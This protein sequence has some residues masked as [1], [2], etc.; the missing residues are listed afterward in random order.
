MAGERIA[1][2]GRVS[3]GE[4][5]V[6]VALPSYQGA[7]PAV[8][9][10]WVKAGDHVAK[11]QKL[12]VTQS[13]ALAA[14]D[15]GVAKA[16]LAA[17]EARLQALS[18][19]PKSEDIATQESTIKSL[20]AEADAVK[21][22]KLPDTTAGKIEATAH[23]EAAQAKV[24]AA[25]H[26]LAALREVRPADLAIGQAEVNEARAAVDRAACAL[27]ATDVEAPIEGQVLAILTSPGEGAAGRGLLELG[28]TAAMV[29]K[30]EV[31]L[32]DVPGLNLGAR[33]HIAGEAW[34][35]KEMGGIVTRISPKVS[36]G[37]PAA[38][39]PFANV[40]RQF[41]E[42]TVTPDDP[43]SFARLSGAEVTVTILNGPAAAK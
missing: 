6:T 13:Q 31:S 14:G 37:H 42:V 23:L 25:Q 17:A 11:G 20:Q 12:A 8:K 26:Q 28:D 34:T 27:A 5:A 33:A 29:I 19:G 7:P 35:G 9:E 22:R 36:R 24:A 1:A 2:F 38:I 43:A 21:A 39:S 3:P 32:A 18:A 16:H 30:A 10:L 40:D 15:L 41:V 4:G